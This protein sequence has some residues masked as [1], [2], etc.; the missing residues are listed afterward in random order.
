MIDPRTVAQEWTTEFRALFG[1]DVHSVVL[2]GSVARGEA[3]PGVSDVNILVLL[4]A[5]TPVQLAQAAPVA[6]R[7]VRA[8][9]TPPLIFSWDEWSRMD[10]TFA[11][12]IS[13]MLDAREVIDGTDPLSD[14]ALKPA[15]LRLHAEREIRE[16][17]LQLR[18]RMLLSVGDPL[19]LGNLLLSGIPSF[20]AYMRAALRLSGEAPGNRTEDVITHTAALIDADP[21]AMLAAQEARRSLRVPELPIGD[22]TVECYTEFARQLVGYIDGL[23]PQPISG[24]SVGLAGPSLAERA[25]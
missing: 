3:I 18:L 11:I 24:Q 10:D 13:D 9:N 21:T 25:R 1:D 12:E 2:F 15:E 16:T 23:P 19:E 17:M 7:W 22:P 4:D 20:S 6:K 8:G 14:K 5:V